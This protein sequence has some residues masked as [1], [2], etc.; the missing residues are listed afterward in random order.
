[1]TRDIGVG[2]LGLNVHHWLLCKCKEEDGKKQ[3]IPNVSLFKWT[4]FN[5]LV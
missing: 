1:M 3:E 5:S 4:D 2:N